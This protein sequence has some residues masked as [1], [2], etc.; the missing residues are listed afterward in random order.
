MT[1][2]QMQ[3]FA[4]T[5]VFNDGS[6][7]SNVSVAAGRELALAAAVQQAARDNPAVPDMVG[8]SINEMPAERLRVMLRLI[9]GQ[10]GQVVSLVSDKP[11]PANWLNIPT[12]PV[13]GEP[14]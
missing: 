1:E 2:P 9:E 11:R 6:M 14:V 7:F 4:V 8:L 12:A 13:G 5:L 3:A 10:P